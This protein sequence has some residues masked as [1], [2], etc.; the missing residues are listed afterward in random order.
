MSTVCVASM[1]PQTLGLNRYRSIMAHFENEQEKP[2]DKATEK[3]A[4][5]VSTALKKIKNNVS[6]NGSSDQPTCFIYKDLS[7]NHDPTKPVL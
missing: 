6:R 3:L 2:L 4:K 5:E 7:V 1:Y